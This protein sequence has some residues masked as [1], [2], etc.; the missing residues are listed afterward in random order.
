MGILEME[1][2]TYYTVTKKYDLSFP[3]LEADID[4]DVVVIG[5][6][7]SGVNTALELAEKG[8]TDIALLE[9]KYLGYGGTS[10][11]GGQVMAGIGHDIE[12]VEKDVGP[13]GVRA[14]LTLSDLGSKII[15]DRIKKYNINA[16]YC[17]GYAYL[18]T[19]NRQK[20]TLETWETEFKALDS[21]SEIYLATGSDIKK[22]IGS[23]LYTSALVH[24]GAGHVHSLNLLLGEAKA[25]A[26]YGA[27]IYE[28]SAAL[29]IEYGDIITV[30]TAKGTVRAK[31]LVWACDSFNNKIE[32]YTYKKTINFYA[33]QM[34]TEPL[35]D[36]MLQRVSP[37]HGAYSDIRPLIDYYR[38]TNEKRLL[39]GGAPNFIEYFPK[40]LKKFNKHRMLKVFPYLKDIKVDLAWGGP[41]ACSVNLFPQIGCLPDLP[42][43]FYVQGYSG[44]G[45][46]PSHIISKVLAEGIV[47]SSD[48]YDLISSV[49]H[50]NILFKDSMRPLLLSVAKTF[51]QLSGYWTGR[52]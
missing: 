38:V 50:K 26:S 21:E 14:I 8:I 17:H 45:V 13:E 24:M 52:R 6:G 34:M 29:E 12:K 7:F 44:F 19:N 20:K 1:S 49:H 47:G 43:V 9:A 5:G 11:N 31:K 30:R 2:P 36:E 39:F 37:I 22:V 48:N 33:Y 4:V 27:K 15:R 42:N 18:G 40:D 32:P 35:S 41:M 51:H 16:D 46:A 23:D 3:S 25:L 28:Y 10:R